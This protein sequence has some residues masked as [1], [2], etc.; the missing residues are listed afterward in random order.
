MFTVL[1]VVYLTLVFIL[2]FVAGRI[3]AVLQKP[4]QA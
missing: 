1:V 4:F 2:S 3:E